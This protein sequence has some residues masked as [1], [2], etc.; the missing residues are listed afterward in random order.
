[1]YIS[2]CFTVS[3]YVLNE[4]STNRYI[5]IKAPSHRSNSALRELIM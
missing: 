4:F 5:I 3:V 2:L 1:M